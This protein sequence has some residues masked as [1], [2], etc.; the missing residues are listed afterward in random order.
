MGSASFL[1]SLNTIKKMRFYTIF[2]S[3]LVVLSLCLSINVSCL[4]TKKNQG[5]ASRL[6]L[7]GSGYSH[8]FFI[9]GTAVD[10]LLLAKSYTPCQIGQPGTQISFSQTTTRASDL[11]IILYN[12]SVVKRS[13]LCTCHFRCTKLA[14]VL[15]P[16]TSLLLL[17]LILPRTPP[18]PSFLDILEFIESQRERELVIPYYT[19]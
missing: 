5:S 13:H 12:T 4:Y 3:L 19:L 14:H 17:L 1:L 2:L 16:V 6:L 10:Q 11:P 18:P 7:V 9:I 15:I 8:F